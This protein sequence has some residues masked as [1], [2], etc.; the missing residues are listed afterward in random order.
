M[1]TDAYFDKKNDVIRVAE[2]VNG[3]RKEIYYP[4]KYEFYY[5]DSNGK[6]LSIYDEPL[7]KILCKSTKEFHT[8]KKKLSDKLLYESDINPVF[9]CIEEYYSDCNIPELNVA[10]FDIETD[11]NKDQGFAPPEDPFNKI[12]SIAVHLS[13]LN[14]T[15]CLALKPDTITQ[16]EA[17]SISEKF[18]DCHIMKDEQELLLTFLTL[19]D[20]ADVLT[21]W[22]STGFDIPYV[23]NRTTLILGKEYNKQLCLWDQYPSK[24]EYEQYGKMNET[25]DLVGRQHLDYLELY[26][27]YTYH[28]MHSYS[29]DAIAEYELD[30]H[31][32]QYDGTLDQLYNEDFEKFLS[33]NIQD[34]DL[35]VK[36]DDKLKFIELANLIAHD[37]GVLLQTTMGSVAQIDQAI[38][39]EAHSHNRHIPDRVKDNNDTTVAGAYVA[40]PKK[41]IHDWV[42]SIDLNSL[43]PSILRALNMSSETIVAQ[44]RLDLTKQM[45]AQ[46]KTV[47]EAW[48]GKFATQEYELVMNKDK[49]TLLHLDFSNGETFEVTGAEI[50]DIVFNSNNPWMLTSNGTIFTTEKKGIIPAL[51][52]RWYA[53]RKQLQKKAKFY[54]AL[55]SGID[56]EKINE[57]LE[58]IP[59]KKDLIIENDKIFHNNSNLVNESI[60][61]WDKR[62]LVKKILLNS[63]Y[64]ALLNVGSRFFDARLGQSTTLTGRC[65]DR[66][67]AAQVNELIAGEYDYKGKAVCYADTDSAYFS[68]YPIL[69]DQIEKGDIQWNKEVAIE[70]YD[71][72]CEEVNK[73]FPEYMRT[74]HNCPDKYN[75]TIAAGREIIGSKALYIK[76]K[77]YAIMVYDDEGNR[78]DIDGKAGKL[79]AMGLD[80]KRSDTPIYMQEFLKEI[81]HM[82]LI[83]TPM[84]DILDRIKKFREEFRQMKPWEKG[85][86]KRVNKLLYYYSKEYRINKNG[87][88]E[89]IKKANMPG[90]VRAAIN[91]NRLLKMHNDKYSMPIVDGMKTV[92]CKLKDNPLGITSI[93]IPTDEK[94]IPEWFKELPFDDNDMEE[95]IVTKKIE[96][97]LGV[98][99]WDLDSTKNNTTFDSLF[100]VL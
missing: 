59:N 85:T 99:G 72:I 24:R 81:L 40:H 77:R 41:G 68:A 6:Y 22:N 2:R 70:F 8:E 37:N 56:A 92:V 98:L 4:V 21:G 96:N 11:F 39:K 36:L 10:Y 27:K 79:K 38:I 43:Y 74:N 71:A 83:D 18:S 90:H 1:Y 29:L 60:E 73:T 66:H 35:L 52:E 75:Y 69:K 5:K 32:V 42:A 53:E 19:I 82:V 34:V 93:G 25:Y 7:T 87:H 16:D 57:V 23:V 54:K 31:K 91:Y 51:L 84:E 80:L 88:E 12:T 97:L 55:K 86:P 95:I 89:F 100:D 47:S 33:Y 17:I 26:R 20:D 63:L 48:E 46:F 78:Q 65:I 67:M 62:Q 14:K 30:E 44:I 64:G 49:S 9:R 58:H 28:E 50:Y 94:R 13:W 45:L 76:K 3:K 15:V 61:F